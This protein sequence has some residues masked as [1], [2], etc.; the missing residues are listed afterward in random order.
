MDERK[1]A[2]LQVIEHK[3]DSWDVLISTGE[4]DRDQDTID[5]LGW[6]IDSYMKNPVVMWGHDYMGVT[7]AGGVPIGKTTALS[8]TS[9]GPVA[10]F[11]FRQPANSGDFVNIVRSAWDQGI[12]NAASVGFR[13][14]KWA[15]RADGGRDFQQQELLEWSIVAIPANGAALRRSYETSLK[16][17]GMG[18]LLDDPRLFKGATIKDET[19]AP[20]EV[21]PPVTPETPVQPEVIPPTEEEDEAEDERMEQLLSEFVSNIREL[22]NNG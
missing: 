17:A 21:A 1:A 7:P 14:I 10:K 22:L 20:V 15:D 5:P 9:D 11:E 2:T 16:A 3:G 13:P 8:I 6:Q 19:P 18:A 12:L 4:V